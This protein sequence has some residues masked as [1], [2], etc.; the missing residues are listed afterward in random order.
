M[1]GD[2]IE[3]LIKKLDMEPLADLNKPTKK[4]AKEM[5][6]FMRRIVKGYDDS[7]KFSSS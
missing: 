5:R 6:A 1:R 2:N 3:E 4:D 7:I